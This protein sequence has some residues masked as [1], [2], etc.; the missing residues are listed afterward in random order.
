M[1]PREEILDAAACLFVNQG[2]AGTSTREIAEAVG[3]RQASLY[4]H[5]QNK[6]EIL[7]ELLLLS[8]RPSLDIF[9]KIEVECPGEVPEATLYLL[10]LIDVDTLARVPHNI[11]KLYA[12]P[13][14][15][16][17]VVYGQFQPAR[18][19]LADAYGRLGAKVVSERV[20]ATVS[21]KQ[22]GGILIEQ[23]ETVI[24]SRADG[25]KVGRA[26]ADAIAA[27]CLRVCGVP[28]DRI[29]QAAAIASDLMSAL[30]EERCTQ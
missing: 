14:V 21:I 22:L 6:D 25:D 7:E 30:I 1:P 27:A 17:N 12:M 20:A 8:V 11:G 23:A 29:D 18:R 3:I 5:F 9:E 2:F 15:M 16:M 13:D 19:E 10:A 24:R 4:H 28:Q 26:E